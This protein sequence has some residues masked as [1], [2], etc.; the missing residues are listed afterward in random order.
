MK[1]IFI[2]IAVIISIV[3]LIT[4]SFTFNQV[5]NERQRLLLDLQHR[6]GI[7]AEN[8]AETLAPNFLQAS[9]SAIQTLVPEFAVDDEEYAGL[10]VYDNKGQLLAVAPDTIKEITGTQ[11]VIENAIDTDTASGNFRKIGSNNFYVFAIPLH[12]KRLTVGSLMIVQNANYIDIRLMDIWRNS[13]LRLFIQVFIISLATL[14]LLRWI[15]YEP[16]RKLVESLQ[17]VGSG[18][19]HKKIP[20]NPLLQPV[21]KEFSRIQTNLTQARLAA[22]E[23][24]R[25]RL[26]KVDSP[27]T[28]EQLKAFVKD[29]LDDRKIIIASNREP[30]I[31]TK[32]NGKISYYFPSGGVVTAIDPI[33][34]ACGGTWV[35]HGSGDAD[36][37][38]VDKNDRIAVPPGES[39]Y[40]LRRV[41]LS[42]EEEDRYYNGF[43]NEG[44]WPL[45]HM[46]HTRPIF[47]K[48]DWEEYKRVNQKFAKAIL[49]E[50]KRSNRPIVLV[51]DFHLALVPAL[52][53]AE[54][55]DATIGIFWHVPW[56]NSEAFSICPFRKEL[57][58]GMLGADIIGFH[59]QLHCNNFIDTVG[60]ELESLIDLE[61][62]AITRN[63]HTAYVKPFPIS[64]AFSEEHA[65]K[66][67]DQS[68]QINTKE[69]RK[70][71]NIQS[72]Y[73]G[74]GVDRLDYTKGM[75]ERFRAIETFLDKY[76]D[77]REQFTFV[78]I[79]P[80]SRSSV[81]KYREFENEVQKEVTR[82][83][84]KF[85]TRTW[86][87]ILLLSKRYSHAEL[88][89]FYQLANLCLVTSL[90]DGMNLVAKEYVAARN[91]E[92][93]VLILS[94]FAGASRELKD[95]FIVNP[96]NIEN[97]ADI[98]K[99]S[100]EMN[101][102]EQSRRM[103]KMRT[104]IKN[105]N[106]YRWSAELLKTLV[107]L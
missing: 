42:K 32:T 6:S 25:L 22:S 39:K 60:K 50:I 46:A 36:R 43:S 30:Y 57:L 98:I 103:K 27:W 48:D 104:V 83:N 17:Q 93:G 10:A 29:I 70:E 44:L 69:I 72:K 21:I 5:E 92:K 88:Q 66:S 106:I 95:A 33:M 47:R 100:L 4:L 41:W 18:K 62:F 31:H 99:E 9:S 67:Y 89:H 80:S 107:N 86:K 16:I 96:Y 28:E 65:Y 35:A 7:I 11:Q 40:T 101:D 15:V 68:V 24:A 71:L 94:Q 19:K 91:D 37:M 2:A 23:E 85:Q 12:D 74:L 75:L 8:L 55:P 82:I 87:P 13:L 73:I 20:N 78:Q 90:H 53:K 63:G 59:T 3:S 76:P 38:V 105:F 49:Q 45:C 77:Y 58:D 54:R 102:E 84:G 52:I 14:L 26:E 51:Q 81:K 64:I 56:P 1:Q 97:M 34:Q 61:Q 79:A